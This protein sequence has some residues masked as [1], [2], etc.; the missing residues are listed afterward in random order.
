MAKSCPFETCRMQNVFLH[1]G[2]VRTEANYI[3][4]A[5][6]VTLI[7]FR[8]IESEFVSS[9]RGSLLKNRRF[10]AQHKVGK[11]ERALVVEVIA[12]DEQIEPINQTDISGIIQ[13]GDSLLRYNGV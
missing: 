3:K 13:I 11:H 2:F 6:N 10:V 9:R 1:S 12:V 8:V 5:K 4:N 7:F